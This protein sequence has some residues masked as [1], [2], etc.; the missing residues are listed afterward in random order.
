MNIKKLTVKANDHHRNGTENSRGFS[1]IKSFLGMFKIFKLLFHRYTPVNAKHNSLDD[2]SNYMQISKNLACS[3][4]PTET[5]FPL[6]QQAGYSVVINLATNDFIECPVD[7]EAEIVDQLGMKY[8][9]IPV[10]FFKPQKRDFDTFVQAMNELKDERIWVHCFMNARASAFI[11]KY[12][13]SV[14]GENPEDALW[15]LREIWE[16]MGVWKKFVYEDKL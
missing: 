12:R 4:Q 16:P 2:I 5:Q 1:S 13:C 8:C 14:L 11:Y 7:N 10:D 9:P 3:G 15:D 6:I